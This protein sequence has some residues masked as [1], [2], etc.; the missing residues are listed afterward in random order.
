MGKTSRATGDANRD[1]MREANRVHCRETR[2]R[3]KRQE[4]MLR[5]VRGTFLAQ[6]EGGGKMRSYCCI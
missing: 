6:N 3:K 1:A 4:Q 5:E 2:E